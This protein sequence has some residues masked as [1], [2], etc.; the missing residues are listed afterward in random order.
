M[1]RFQE[2]VLPILRGALPES[3]K[4]GSWIEDV[5][6][7]GYPLV[8]V[9]R[10]GGTRS[11]QRPDVLDKPVIE[12]TVIHDEGLVECEDLYRDC[13]DALIKASKTQVGSDVGYIVYARETMGMTQFS[14]LFVDTFRVQG[15]IE[16][17]LRPRN[18]RMLGA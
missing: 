11:K 5:D 7:R 6:K 1:P 17:G 4:V 12:M 14:S 18:V 3:V 9:R 15:L 13:L 16:V 2:V 8:N 10:L